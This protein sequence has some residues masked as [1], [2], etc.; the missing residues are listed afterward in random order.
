MPSQTNSQDAAG[1]MSRGHG[2]PLA[3]RRRAAGLIVGIALIAT[4]GGLWWYSSLAGV[5]F[6]SARGPGRW[7]FYPTFTR[8]HREVELD[9]TFRKTFELDAVPPVARLSIRGF[10]KFEVSINGVRIP[11]TATSEAGWKQQSALDVS[12]MLRSGKNAI[13]AVVSNDKGPPA[14]WLSLDCGKRQVVSDTSWTASYAGA[15]ELHVVDANRPDYEV[16]LTP[17]P[18]RPVASMGRHWARLLLFGIA[19][20]VLWATVEWWVRN[21]PDSNIA[22]GRLPAKAMWLLLGGWLMIWLGLGLN[23]LGFLMPNDGFDAKWH[24]MNIEYIQQH[25]ALPP[26]DH[27]HEAHQPPLYY[28]VAAAFLETLQLHAEDPSGIRALRWLS[29]FF[30]AVHVTLTALILRRVSRGVVPMVAGLIVAGFLPMQM[31]IFQY[32]SNEPLVAVFGSA[33]I[34]LCLRIV[35]STRPSVWAYVG[36]GVCLGA[37][38]STKLTAAV[39]VPVVI[40]VVI[41]RLMICRRWSIAGRLS[42]IGGMVTAMILVGGGHYL[43]LWYHL[44]SPLARRIDLSG[45]SYWV[46]PGFHGASHFWQF[47]ESLRQPFFAG[48]YSLPDALY[49]TMWGD[50]RMGGSGSGVIQ[51]RPPWDY[52]LMACGYLLALAVSAA[53]VLGLVVL[54]GQLVRRPGATRFLWLGGVTAM[55]TALIYENLHHPYLWVA[56]SWYAVPISSLLCA[57]AGLGCA[58]V[59]RGGLIARAAVFI[60]LGTWAM[61]SLSSFWIA[62]NANTHATL[63]AADIAS[64][65]RA[66]S[67]EHVQQALGENPRHALALQIRGRLL[68]SENYVREAESTWKVALQVDPD[69]AYTRYHLAVLLGRLG[70]VAEA[71]KHL[72]LAV[73]LAPDDAVIR[74]AFADM[75]KQIH[76]STEAVKQFRQTLRIEPFSLGTHRRLVELYQELSMPEKAQQHCRYVLALAPDDEQANRILRLLSESMKEDDIE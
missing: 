38:L 14:L 52:A 11:T 70:R 23:N 56:K 74:F 71:E 13:E 63:A 18:P 1:E 25:Y 15:T 20:L 76:R 31:Y 48:V 39:L 50:A 53:I 59:A 69:S 73:E 43:R 40:A 75:Y 19:S 10:R 2:I 58:T 36:L 17:P 12:D 28:L 34:Y 8:M 37:G 29:M 22:H 62:D 33:T 27:G 66:E 32:I 61:C 21:H 7:V 60:S 4:L 55:A 30:A 47:G 6:L 45:E 72:L 46:Q 24:L 16:R 68:L 57:A 9:T 3:K 26:P 41:G 49:S 51:V 64:G 5:P 44:G 65:R 35:Q 67:L 42:R 54:T